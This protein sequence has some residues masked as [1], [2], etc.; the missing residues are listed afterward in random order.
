MSDKKTYFLVPLAYDR[1]QNNTGAGTMTRCKALREWCVEKSIPERQCIVVLTAGYTKKYPKFP[2]SWPY[3]SLAKQMHIY[4]EPHFI[5]T[6]FI[7]EPCAWGTHAEIKAAANIIE[8]LINS[9]IS[10]S[11]VEIVTS[12]NRIHLYGRVWLWWWK[13]ATTAKLKVT[14]VEA[15]HRF[16]IWELAQEVAKII[17]DA[18]R[19]IIE[20]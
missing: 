9:E 5:N 4:M 20:K 3:Q 2:L 19:V 14:L 13:Y 18:F 8:G 7:V 12:S 16:T 10:G 15:S 6:R 1:I 11:H 17:R